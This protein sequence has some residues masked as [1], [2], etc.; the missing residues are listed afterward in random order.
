ML[1]TVYAKCTVILECMYECFEGFVDGRHTI[2]IARI[3]ENIMKVKEHLAKDR[4]GIVRMI[5]GKV[6]N[7]RET[8]QTL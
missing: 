5:A 3:P 7:G 6:R 2:V 8:A 4:R 1:V